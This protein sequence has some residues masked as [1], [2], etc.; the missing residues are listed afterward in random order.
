[1]QQCSGHL[2]NHCPWQDPLLSWWYGSSRILPVQI[3]NTDFKEI[4]TSL[5]IHTTPL[6][7]LLYKEIGSPLQV[8]Y[9]DIVGG[10]ELGDI[11]PN[12]H[13]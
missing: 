11:A 8:H 1:V 6:E 13:L 5:Y 10:L 9:T 7:K 12:E 4:Y 3:D 2:E